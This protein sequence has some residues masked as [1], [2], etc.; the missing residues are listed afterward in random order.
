MGK[1]K[2]IWIRYIKEVKLIGPEDRLVLV[3]R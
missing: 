1:E 3:I 2:R